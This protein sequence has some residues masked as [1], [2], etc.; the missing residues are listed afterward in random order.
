MS[1]KRARSSASSIL[2]AVEAAAPVAD[3]AEIRDLREQIARL[4]GQVDRYRTRYGVL[5]EALRDVFRD[6]PP[7]TIP[8]APKRDTRKREQRIAVLHVSDTQLGKRTASYSMDI[9]A[10]RLELLVDLVRKITETQRSSY[11]IDECRLYL[12]G[13]LVEGE[14]IF[15]GQAH[16]IDHS[17]LDQAVRIGPS[18]IVRMVL[19][20]LATFRRVRVVAV[21]GNHGRDDFESHPDTNW[22]TVCAEVVRRTLLG[23]ESHPRRELDGRLDMV[24]STDWKYV[25]R[26]PGGWGNLIVHGHQIRGGFAGFPWYGAGRKSGGWY[27]VVAEPWDYLYFGHFHTAAMATVNFTEWR[28]NGT[29]E[30]GNDYAAAEMA[31]AGYPS[32][33]LTFYNADHGL[34]QEHNLYLTQPGER[35][36]AAQ[37]F[38]A[39]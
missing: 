12:G 4:Q 13:D 22:D 34:V 1:D 17:L 24:V 38:Q 14:R 27:Q 19:S 30:S 32:Q 35:V 6:P 28:A 20:L 29:T 21:S 8:P 39:P 16:L 7:I 25:D 9:G 3:P 31:A 18:I 23:D 2:D 10:R 36:P 26:M 15:R 11:A 33:R 5:R 37:R